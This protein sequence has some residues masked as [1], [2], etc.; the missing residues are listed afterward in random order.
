VSLHDLNMAAG[1]CDD[2]LILKDGYPQ[3]FGPP[4]SLLT[5]TLVSDTFR[6]QARREQLAP[7]GAPHFSFT[8]PL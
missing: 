4:H 3:G 1:I 8:L 7:S 5:D 6:V 2:V